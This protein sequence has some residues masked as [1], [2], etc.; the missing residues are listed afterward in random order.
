MPA[1]IAS[2]D[3]N[4]PSIAMVL[5]G[6]HAV[7]VIGFDWTY[8]GGRPR[9]DAIRFHDPIPGYANMYLPAYL[10]KQGYFTAPD[11]GQLAVIIGFLKYI[12]DGE[13][14]YSDFLDQDG[15]YYGGPEEYHP[16]EVAY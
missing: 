3:D 9:A 16:T 1:Q 14:G 6:S 12:T 11:G 8:V 2:V 5:K 10:W 15:T 7:I 4:L 13:N